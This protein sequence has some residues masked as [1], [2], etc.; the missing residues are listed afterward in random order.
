MIMPKELQ[1]DF[2]KFVRGQ[3]YRDRCYGR[4]SQWFERV[5]LAFIAGHSAALRESNKTL[6]K[7][8]KRGS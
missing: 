5:Q 8:L 6:E 3:S 4:H 1:E 2:D 7:I